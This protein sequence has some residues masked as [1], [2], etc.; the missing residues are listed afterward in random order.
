MMKN[1]HKKQLSALHI[2]NLTVNFRIKLKIIIHFEIKMLLE[3]FS[4]EFMNFI[5][6]KRP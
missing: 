5:E 6:N 2:Y 1:E 4:F 3:T